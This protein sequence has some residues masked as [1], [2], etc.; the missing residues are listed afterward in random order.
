MK[1]LCYWIIALSFI[2]LTTC[3][4][5]KYS[6]ETARKVVSYPPCA[7]LK[8][9]NGFFDMSLLEG[10]GFNVKLPIGA[11]TVFRSHDCKKITSYNIRYYWY[12]KKMSLDSIHHPKGGVRIEMLYRSSHVEKTNKELLIEKPWYFDPAIPHSDF[13]LEYY[14]RYGWDDPINPSKESQMIHGDSYSWGI[15]NSKFI[16][17][18][19]R[20]KF[21]G[22]CGLPVPKNLSLSTP[23]LSGFNSNSSYICTGNVVVSKYGK[24]FRYTLRMTASNENLQQVLLE[25]D[26]IIP[27]LTT[28]LD[29]LIMEY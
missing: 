12:Q 16:N 27:A 9:T 14:P 29:T 19:I 18:S 3:A 23:V 11:V 15:K 8:I 4:Y 6:W 17:E 21:L 1:K 22:G 10:S 24:A 28:E 13:P 2:P 5:L 26:E 7:P 25:M 20:R